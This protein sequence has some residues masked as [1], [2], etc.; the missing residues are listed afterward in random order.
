MNTADGEFCTGTLIA[1]YLALTAGPC[2]LE[3]DCSPIAAGRMTFLAGLADRTAIAEV[4]VARTVAH[5]DFTGS[6]PLTEDQ[7]KLNVAMLQ[8]A[9]PIPAALAAPFAVG[10]T[11]AGAEVSVASYV[12]GREEAPSWQKVCSVLGQQNGLVAGGCDVTFGASGAPM[13]DRSAGRSKIVSIISSGSQDRGDKVAFGMDLPDLVD[14][15]KA[16]LRQGKVLS[17]EVT[18]AKLTIRRIGTGDGSRDTGA[19]LVKP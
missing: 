1:T 15:L 8:L 6:A 11:G 16:R 3:R 4:R 19:R 10:N 18:R 17:E 13:P 9:V 5:P 2:V 7:L 14:T 12:K